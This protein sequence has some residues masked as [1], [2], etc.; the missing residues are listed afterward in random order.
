MKWRHIEHLVWW[1]LETERWL[2]YEDW[3]GGVMWQKVG[4]YII[5]NFKKGTLQPELFS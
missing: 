3:G 5:K 1:C 4:D 2:E